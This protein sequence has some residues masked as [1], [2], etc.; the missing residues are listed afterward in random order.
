MDRKHSQ[1]GLRRANGCGTQTGHNGLARSDVTSR[2][3]RDRRPD[4]TT[5]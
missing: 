2:P 5:G 3:A 4:I 1:S